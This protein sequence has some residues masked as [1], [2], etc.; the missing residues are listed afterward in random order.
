MSNIAFLI[1]V[2]TVTFF[3]ISMERESMVFDFVIY[4]TK[5]LFLNSSFS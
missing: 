4:Q 3:F 5:L 1:S 2:N